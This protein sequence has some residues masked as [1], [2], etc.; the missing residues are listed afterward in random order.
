M[1]LKKK[2]IRFQEIEVRKT[3]RF[4]MFHYKTSESGFETKPK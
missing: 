3:E 2:K 4:L 1:E